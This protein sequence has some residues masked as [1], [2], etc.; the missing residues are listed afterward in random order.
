M[1]KEAKSPTE[2][3]SSQVLQSV[4]ADDSFT[5]LVSPSSENNNKSADPGNKHN[6][7]AFSEVV[8][9]KRNPGLSRSKV[10]IVGQ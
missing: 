7:I 6:Q 10:T 5:I 8:R 4:T 9:S 2:S 3:V 1:G